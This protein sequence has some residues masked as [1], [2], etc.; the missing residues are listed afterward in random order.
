VTI[1]LGNIGGLCGYT[2]GHRTN[3][4][5]TDSVTIDLNTSIWN[6][7]PGQGGFTAS[8]LQRTL[9]HE[10]GHTLGLDDSNTCGSSSDADMD[11]NFYCDMNVS[12][13]Q[14]TFGDVKAVNSSL[15]GGKTRVRCG[16]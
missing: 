16:F 11:P 9:S 3:G 7:Q 1:R 14:P 5:F 8:G 12:L 2:D 10:R 15:Y 13:T 6:A 4:V